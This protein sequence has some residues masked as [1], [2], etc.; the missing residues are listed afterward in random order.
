MM[1]HCDEI[2]AIA[3]AERLGGMDGYQLLLAAV[4]SSLLFSFLNGASSYAPYSTKLLVNHYQ[5]SHFDKHQKGAL[6][7]T[8]F[9]NSNVNFGGDTK[10]GD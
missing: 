1:K 2:L 9:K 8:P 4:K 7:S 6:F 5:L 10:A 3:L